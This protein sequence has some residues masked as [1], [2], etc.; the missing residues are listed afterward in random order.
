MIKV[1]PY[2]VLGNQRLI[3]P[4]DQ[5]SWILFQWETAGAPDHCELQLQFEADTDPKAPPTLRSEGLGSHVRIVFRNWRNPMGL[6]TAS[7]ILVG[8]T[9]AGGQL[10][11]MAASW[12]TGDTRFIEIQLMEGGAR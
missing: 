4:K 6:S 8:K 10:F 11:F 5:E 1:G 9:D 2:R 7:P 3:I 12:M